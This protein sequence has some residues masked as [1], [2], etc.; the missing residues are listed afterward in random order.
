M[1][2]SLTGWFWSKRLGRYRADGRPGGVC[3]RIDGGAF[4]FSRLRETLSAL[5]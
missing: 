3:A 1:P 5:R 2:F 4:L